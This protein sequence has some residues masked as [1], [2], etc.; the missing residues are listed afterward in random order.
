MDIP[1]PWLDYEEEAVSSHG[2]DY[3]EEAV[4]SHGRVE[5]LRL[6]R[7]PAGNLLIHL[8][9]YVPQLDG[10]GGRISTKFSVNGLD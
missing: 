10:W 9:I 1:L 2:L 3:E 7:K 6:G 8:S 4:S 5:A